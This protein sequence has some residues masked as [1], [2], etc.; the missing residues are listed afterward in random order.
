[1]KCKRRH[2]PIY[3][4]FKLLMVE[5]FHI[6][7]KISTSHLGFQKTI[8][9]V[10]SFVSQSQSISPC[11]TLV[12]LNTQLASSMQNSYDS[13]SS[14]LQLFLVLL[15]SPNNFIAFSCISN[16]SSSRKSFLSLGHNNVFLTGGF[17]SLLQDLFL[18][19]VLFA[20]LVL[21][22]IIKSIFVVFKVSSFTK[23]PGTLQML[24]GYSN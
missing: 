7:L 20:Y 11:F 19:L 21:Q 22:E 5:H 2:F 12:L 9:M 16:I 17:P 8:H 13:M 23:I 1:M 14:S 4:T 6:L 3:T 24:N 15:P 10:S 18:S